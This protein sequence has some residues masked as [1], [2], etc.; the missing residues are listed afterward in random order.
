[1]ITQLVHREE[2]IKELDAKYGVTNVERVVSEYGTRFYVTFGLGLTLGTGSEYLGDGDSVWFARIW[3]PIKKQEEQIGFG[4]CNGA[5]DPREQVIVDPLDAVKL[6]HAAWVAEQ[7]RKRDE[8]RKKHEEEDRKY[9]AEVEARTPN[10][11]KTVKVV[12]GR[13]VPKGLIGKV[14]WYG[15]TRYGYRVGIEVADGVRLFTA[16]SNVEVIPS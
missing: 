6:E 1:M 13:K 8:L 7:N 4:Y 5:G 12:R 14:F 16:D 10:R 3:N 11:G 9:R 15:Q 2:D